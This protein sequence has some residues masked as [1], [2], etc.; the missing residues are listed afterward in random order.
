M[1]APDGERLVE[2]GAPIDP[3]QTLRILRMGRGDESYRI[4][5]SSVTLACRSPQGPVALRFEPV[6]RHRVR[7]LAWGPGA[8]H[9]LASAD[10][11][12]GVDDDPGTFDPTA[13]GRAPR[14]V[15]KRLRRMA[16]TQKGLRMGRTLSL[17]DC[18]LRVVLQQRVTWI[19]AVRAKRYLTRRFGEPSPLPELRLPADPRALTLGGFFRIALRR[20]LAGR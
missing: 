20:A 19:E 7:V 12:L 5:R 9:G 8:E 4:D 15:A 17:F 18:L 16:E 10:R 2:D 6:D 14:A 13:G 1:S 3:V 11:L